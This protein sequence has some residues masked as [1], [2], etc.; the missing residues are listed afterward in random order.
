MGIIVP[1]TKVSVG[2][3][4]ADGDTLAEGIAVKAPGDLTAR[5]L[6]ELADDV[7]LPMGSGSR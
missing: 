3:A 2:S 5:I 6:K 7:D 4:L 1:M